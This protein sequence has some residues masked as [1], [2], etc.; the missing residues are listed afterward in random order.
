ML[1]TY[2]TPASHELGL[3]QDQIRQTVSAICQGLPR[4]RGLQLLALGGEA[5]FAAAQLA[6][7]WDHESPVGIPS[8][9]YAGLVDEVLSRSVDETV[10]AYHLSFVEAET[11][12]PA[13]YFYRRL[14]RSLGVRE[15]LVSG[16][17][18]RNGILLEMARPGVWVEALRDQIIAPA[19]EVGRK[20][21]VNEAHVEHVASLCGTLF[22]ALAD[23][24]K[25]GP[26]HELLLTVAALLHDVGRFVSE[27]NHHKHSY[28][29]IQHSE[30]FGLS[31][32]DI[33]L[34]ALV[35]RYHRRA[36]PKPEHEGFTALGKEGRVIVAK[37]AAILRVAD[38][39][40]RSYNQRVRDIVC[41]REDGRFIIEVPHLTDLSP[42]SFALRGKG[43]MFE[44]V[45]GMGVALRPMAGRGK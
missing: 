25:L 20:Y 44:D 27:R 26:R 14:G 35:A 7:G 31:T 30:L 29:L 11:L 38:A 9:Q 12:A 6:E 45:Y 4:K 40:D 16:V 8:G 22:A 15:L 1:E 43:S 3:M 34:V 28:Y 42:E 18:A 24:H 21:H 13:L 5:R 10:R 19:R 2:R 37:L 33:Q 36:S 32:R 39:L 41:R 17:S 23:E